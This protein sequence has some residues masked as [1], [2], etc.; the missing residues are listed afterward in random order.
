MHA[1]RFLLRV[2][3]L[4]GLLTLSSGHAQDWPQWRGPFF[5]GAGHK[6]PLPTTFSKTEGVAW[7]AP[8]SGPAA[9]TPVIVGDRIF[10]T[11]TDAATRSLLA[12]CLDRK[13]GRQLWSHTVAVGDRKDH[14]SNFASSSPLSD[15]THVWFFYGQGDLLACTVEGREVW[16]RN[17]QKDH[18]PFAF[19]WTFSSSPILFDGRLYLQVL[20]RD[21]PVDGRGRTDGPN[22]SY[23]LAMDPATGRDLWRHVRPSAAEGES[24]ES[25]ATPVPFTH[26]GRSEILVSG[27]DCFTGH[28][29]VT[30][31][32]L[33]RWGTWNPGKITHWRLVVSPVAG[34][35]MALVAA[36]KGGPVFAIRSGQNG[37]L[38]ADGYAWKSTEREVS[39]DVS[40]PLF[41]RGRFYVVNSD[42]R[43]IL[44][45]EP[46]DG[47][48]VWK[49]E[50]P[51]GSKIEASPTAAD[52]KIYVISHAGQAFVIDT[53][54][55][56]KILHS[57]PMGGDQ[58]LEVRSSIAL[59]HGHL[60]LRTTDTLYAIGP[61]E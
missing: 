58:D 36:P 6:Q 50:L 3:A 22:E 27:G 34:A 24:L 52:G 43:L 8:M 53:G 41:Y 15:G 11:S 12:L 44:S 2:V 21:V 32:E 19:G 47:R 55:E 56:F 18:G 37:T 30:G 33:W 38:P 51:G 46:A 25:F 35:G 28:D 17:I 48:V 1:R 59:A 29:P 57:T 13:T 49:G 61:R 14:R 40:T 31:R 9:S 60:Y 4:A 10:L 54:D 23:L 20:Q 45:V 5:N 16:R 26:E 39:S 7:T 42:R